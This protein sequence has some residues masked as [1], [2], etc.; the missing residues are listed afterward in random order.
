MAVYLWKLSHIC[1]HTSYHSNKPSLCLHQNVW[2]SQLKFL[3][4]MGETMHPDTQVY[5]LYLPILDFKP[6]TSQIWFF[7][8]WSLKYFHKILKKNTLQVM[9]PN[10]LSFFYYIINF[11]HQR[12]HLCLVTSYVSIPSKQNQNKISL[13]F[14]EQ[15]LGSAG[16][17]TVKYFV[18]RKFLSLTLPF[19]II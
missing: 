1:D 18:S 13:N 6:R 7:K 11:F 19:P 9:K 4:T 2:V 5:G 17:S 16:Y 15:R 8:T 3:F 12:H 14:A 10:F